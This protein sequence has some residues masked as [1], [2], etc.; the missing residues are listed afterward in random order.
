LQQAFPEFR[1]DRCG[2]ARENADF[3]QAFATKAGCQ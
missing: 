2:I 3:W 1:N